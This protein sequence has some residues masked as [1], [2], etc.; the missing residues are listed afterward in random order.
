MKKYIVR[1][2]PKER[3]ESINQEYRRGDLNPHDLAVTGF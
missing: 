2:S 3:E 1:L